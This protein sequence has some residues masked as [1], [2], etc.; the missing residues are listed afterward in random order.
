MM[1]PHIYTHVRIRCIIILLLSL[2]K[3]PCVVLMA[4]STS[5]YLWIVLQRGAGGGLGIKST[6]SMPAC[7]LWHMHQTMTSNS[8][9]YAAGTLNQQQG[10]KAGRKK[11]SKVCLRFTKRDDNS[12][13]WSSSTSSQQSSSS[14]WQS[15]MKINMFLHCRG[16]EMFSVG[17]C[18]HRNLLTFG[19]LK[20]K[21]RTSWQDELRL[22]AEASVLT[23]PQRHNTQGW[24]DPNLCPSGQ[25]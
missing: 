17:R 1:L 2:F 4:A 3:W 23:R 5:A 16:T 18:V 9:V 14:D 13:C 6:G 7:F 24:L 8:C 15:K 22:W 25:P 21:E 20:L 19:M 11:Q 10:D 12:G